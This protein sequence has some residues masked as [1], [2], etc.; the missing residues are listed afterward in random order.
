MLE[1]I[2]NYNMDYDQQINTDSLCYSVVILCSYSWVFLSFRVLGDD[3]TYK[4]KVRDLVTED[5]FRG[6]F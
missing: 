2:Q 6:S 1:L 4:P 5:L 3:G